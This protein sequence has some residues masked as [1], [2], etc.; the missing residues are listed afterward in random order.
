MYTGMS[1]HMRSTSKNANVY[2]TRGTSSE[3]FAVL[4]MGSTNLYTA[5]TYAG[6]Q[7]CQPEQRQPR[8]GVHLSFGG[9]AAE[10]SIEHGAHRD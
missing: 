1:R 5:F 9:A 4:Y 8:K 7:N 3:S 6:K 2:S 10:I